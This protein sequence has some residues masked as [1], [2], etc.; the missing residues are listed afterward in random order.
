MDRLKHF[1]AIDDVADVPGLVQKALDFK[2]NRG[3]D[4]QLGKGK[5][6]GL[7]FMNPSLRTRIS[8]QKAAR[9]L[10]AEVIVMNM[11]KEGWALEFEEEVVMNGTKVEHIKEAAAVLGTYCDI[12]GFRSF[13]GL[14]DR[15]LDYSDFVF[16]Q[17]QKYAGVPMISLESATRHPLQSFADLI[18]IEE[19][20]PKARPKVVLAWAPHIKP[21]PQAVPNSFAE[22]M[23][24]ADVDFHIAQP[25]GYELHPD[26]QGKAK[27]HY[28]LESGIQDADFVYVKNWS[29]YS[30]YGQMP[31]V[32]GDW[33]MDLSRWEKT[34]KAGV[35]H[36]LP[37]RRGLELSHELLDHSASLVIQQAENRLWSALTAMHEI[38]KKD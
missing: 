2:N 13:P 19:H 29:S 35:M 25:S 5:T 31:A 7:V 27:V 23:N 18:T 33:M 3:F 12:I 30:Q 26:F 28:D 10:G 38:L 15:D 9:M 37:V 17:F 22:W 8:S 21:L 4:P 6:I 16:R 20:K 1:T 14:V 32:Q 24:A 36:C 34:N 11:D